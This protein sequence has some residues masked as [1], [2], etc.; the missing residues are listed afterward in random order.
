MVFVAYTTAPFVLFI[1]LGL[2]PYARRSRAVLERFVRA[3]PPN[4]QL[5]FTTM[6]WL[7]RPRYTS[8]AV[9]D[10]GPLPGRFSVA[11]YF[12]SKA[13]TTGGGKRGAAVTRF[14]IQGTNRGIK[15]GWVWDA[16]RERAAKA[17]PRRA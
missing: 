13:T 17:P 14:N 8:V 4:T 15:E 3:S 2:P 6:S 7:T 10:L 1:H 12:A 9:E 16:T 11:N 5:L